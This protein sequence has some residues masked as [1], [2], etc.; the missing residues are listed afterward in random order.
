VVWAPNAVAAA[1]TKTVNAAYAGRNDLS[2]N[3]ARCSVTFRQ[4]EHDAFTDAAL[5]NGTMILRYCTDLVGGASITA[6]S[7]GN[8]VITL[9]NRDRI[10]GTYSGVNTDILSS[11]YTGTLTVTGGTGK[12]RHASGTLVQNATVV[13]FV[14]GV[15]WQVTGTLVGTITR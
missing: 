14:P 10:R 9:H 2:P 15:S 6:V 13:S 7:S 5:G 11:N 3:D 4:V 8:F 1:P 12:W